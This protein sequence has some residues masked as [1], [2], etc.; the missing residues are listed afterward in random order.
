[1]SVVICYKSNFLSLILT[2]TRISYGYSMDGEI[3]EYTDNNEKLIELPIGWCAGAGIHEFI[4]DI[5]DG[6]L[7]NEI[8]NIPQVTNVYKNTYSKFKK[9]TNYS[10]KD[11]NISAVAVSYIGKCE[12]EITPNFNIILLNEKTIDGDKYAIVNNENIYI[13]F[14]IEYIK[15]KHLVDILKSKFLLHYDFDGDINKLIKYILEIFE[16]I[17]KNSNT[18]SEICDIGLMAVSEGILYKIRIN[19]NLETLLKDINNNELSKHFQIID[20]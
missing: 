8:E 9:Y 11:I 15:D 19:N 3:V 6:L 2:D 13:L 7:N 16:E 12:N 10:E 17:S 4:D 20:N 18:V 5:K 1:M 14:P